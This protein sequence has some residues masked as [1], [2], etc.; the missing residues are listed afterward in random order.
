MSFD[1]HQPVPERQ[2][3]TGLRGGHGHRPAGHRARCPPS[4]TAAT[5]ATG[6]TRSPLPTPPPT[7]GSPATAWC[8]ASGSAT[9]GPSGTATAGC[10]RRRVAAG[11]GRGAARPAPRARRHGLRRQ[12]QRDRPRRP[13]VRDRRGRRPPVRADRRARHRRPAPTSAARCPA[14]SP[15][16]RSAT[17]S[18]ASCTR[19]SYYWG[20]GNDVQYI[21]DRHRR[22]GAARPSTSR[23]PA[24]RWCTT[25]DHRDATRCSTT[26]RSCST[27][28][29]RWRRALPVPRGTP[30]TAPASGCC[31]ATATPTDVRW[32]DVEPCY[33][34]HP[35]NAYDDGD[36]RRARRGAPPEDVRHATASG[37]NEGPPT[38]ERWTLDPAAGQGASRS[39]STTG[40]QEFPRVDERR[41]RPAA[42]ATAG[43]RRASTG[44]D[45][46]DFEWHDAI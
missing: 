27:S 21:V 35:L 46:V 16:T 17:R 32:F 23:C 43:L 6:R 41:R 45:G 22:H 18:P 34:F 20:W 39:S 12:H 2:L 1:E 3:R 29:P 36:T 42:T 24:A 14:G 44:D 10:A 9:A 5:C 15:P 30:T 31:R 28:R 25:V 37:P 11:A 19:S 40:G 33:V 13:H 4:W 8:T 38:L 26:C 7:T